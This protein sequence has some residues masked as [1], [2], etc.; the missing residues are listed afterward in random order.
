[1]CGVLQASVI[2]CSQDP[3]SV[4]CMKHGKVT[5]NVNSQM[6][7]IQTAQLCQVS[8]IIFFKYWSNVW[9]Y[10]TAWIKK[11]Q[12]EPLLPSPDSLAEYSTPLPHVTVFNYDQMWDVPMGHVGWWPDDHVF[13]QPN[14]FSLLLW[15][16]IMKIV[17]SLILF[18]FRWNLTLWMVPSSSTWILVFITVWDSVRSTKRHICDL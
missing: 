16:H 12:G 7:Q 5:A 9:L 3:L 6:W 1:M 2:N 14:V 8:V 13:S 10:I 17:W 11:N 4:A 18:W 15:T